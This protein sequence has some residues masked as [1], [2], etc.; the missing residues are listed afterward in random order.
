MLGVIMRSHIIGIIVTVCALSIL[1]G[2]EPSPNPPNKRTFPKTILGTGFEPEFSFSRRGFVVKPSRIRTG[3]GDDY[4]DLSH[5][6]SWQ[7]V[8]SVPGETNALM[9]VAS[10][11]RDELNRALDARCEDEL[12]TKKFRLRPG[13]PFWGSLCYD[14]NGAR[15][16]VR[17]W[18]IPHEQTSAM[19]YVVYLRA[20][21]LPK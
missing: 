8:V 5:S 12:T 19:S 16:D 20:A 14:K 2:A 15:V 11:I 18:L 4:M 21:D 3:G 6:E 1:R 13:Q 17:V 10:A 7:G 9:T